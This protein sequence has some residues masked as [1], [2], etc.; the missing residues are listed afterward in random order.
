MQST[1]LSPFIRTWR[2]TSLMMFLVFISMFSI[3][4]VSHGLLGKLFLWRWLTIVGITL[5]FELFMNFIYRIWTLFDGSALITSTI[6]AFFLPLSLSWIAL[7]QI[8]F[9][10]IF[11]A[12]WMLGGLGF[13]YVNPS[14][15][16]LFYAMMVWPYYFEYYWLDPSFLVSVIGTIVLNHTTLFLI[17]LSGFILML[18]KIISRAVFFSFTLSFIFF[19]F[20]MFANFKLDVAFSYIMLNS[21]IVLFMAVFI[22]TNPSNLPGSFIGKI[23][24]GF[25]V[26]FL[27]VYFLVYFK[28]KAFLSIPLSV[29]VANIL[30]PAIN[31]FTIRFGLLGAW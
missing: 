3:A 14:M 17:A 19:F 11:V 26:G 10:T 5:G 28:E 30:S 18:M 7:L 31:Y 6:L 20:M 12:K 29:L 23:T 27:M 8:I 1:R 24:Y 13:N 25:L 15:F 21:W 16:G 4:F 22:V 2:S 9:L